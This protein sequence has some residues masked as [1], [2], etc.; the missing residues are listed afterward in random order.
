M[1]DPSAW[2]AAVREGAEPIFTICSDANADPLRAAETVIRAALATLERH[3][4]VLAPKKATGAM[5]DA[6][7]IENNNEAVWDAMLAARS[8]PKV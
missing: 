8:K 7:F 6:A 1:T 3:A 4:Y 5:L 2:Q